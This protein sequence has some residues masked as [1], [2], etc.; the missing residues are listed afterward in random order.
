MPVIAGARDPRSIITPDAFQVAPDLLGLPLAKPM[1]RLVAIL[2]D[3]AL[4]GLITLATKSFGMVLG[5]VAAVFFI[6][7]GF[8]RTPVQN[9]AF[10]RAMRLSV[11]CL[12]VFIAMGTAA[13]WLLLRGNAHLRQQGRATP[14]VS[15]D[16]VVTGHLSDAL[17]ILRVGADLRRAATPEDAR[18]ALRGMVATLRGLGL[19]DAE[20]RQSAIDMFPKD[21]NWSGDAASIVDD[22]L[23]AAPAAAAAPTPTTSSPS[24][25]VSALSIPDALDAYATMLRSGPGDAASQAR[26]AALRSRLLDTLAAD[27][28][29]ALQQSLDVE[30]DLAASRSAKIDE[31]TTAAAQDKKGDGIIGWIKGAVDEL[32]FGFGW[33]SIY[34]T[35]LTSW[36][37]GQTVGKRIMK[38]RVLRLDGE[39]MTW[40]AAFERAGGYAA[41][42]ATGLLGFAQVYWDANRQCIHDRISGT[43]VVQDGAPKVLDWQDAL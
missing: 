9:S 16:G 8:K 7:A 25:D 5:I 14:S 22:V 21:K 33:A 42:F 28:L 35:I 37:R 29:R 30:Q 2:I 6:R 27:T 15:V 34:L 23:G 43:V 13:G 18:V 24:P 12:G 3:L 19:D 36:W 10:N 32:G 4:I 38:I 31:L 11:G 40:W 39:P 41:G 1:Q 20:I 17:S 26:L